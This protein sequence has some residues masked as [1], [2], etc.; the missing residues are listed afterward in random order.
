[1]H[2][3]NKLAARVEALTGP[4]RET[5]AE[6]APLA[7]FYIGHIRS[8]GDVWMNTE[9]DVWDLP[10]F[11]ASLDAAMS[12]VPRGWIV[13]LLRYFN[14]DGEYWSRAIL[15]DSFTVGRGRDPEEE[16]SVQSSIGEKRAGDDPT[17]R[18]LTAAALR[19]RAAMES[20]NE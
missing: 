10:A 13:S 20:N 4:C 5:D 12:L 6:I 14:G 15:T 16:R 2:D 18:A 8:L 17:P 1:M 11:T 3:L 9:G 19:A 7:G